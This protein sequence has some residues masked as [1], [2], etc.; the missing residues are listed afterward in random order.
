LAVLNTQCALQAAAPRLP[1]L[2]R[3]FHSSEQDYQPNE[4]KQTD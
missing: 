2:G 3:V 1:M 4:P